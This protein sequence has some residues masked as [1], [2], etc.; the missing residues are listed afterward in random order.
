MRLLLTLCSVATAALVAGASGRGDDKS[1]GYECTVSAVTCG[2][3]VGPTWEAGLCG[4]VDLKKFGDLPDNAYT[5][6]TV[7][8]GYRVSG[9][10]IF[11]GGAGAKSG[12]AISCKLPWDDKAKQPR[13]DA[14]KKE[15]PALI[16]ADPSLKAKFP[17][18]KKAEL[19]KAFKIE[20]VKPD[21]A[22]EV[23][24]HKDYKDHPK[25]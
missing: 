6:V 19:E 22:N 15:L 24:S 21:K 14:L 18:L 5:Q 7:F 25:K 13:Y 16:L 8:V 1:S 2:E 20:P 17:G 3:M 23:L 4:V 11:L 10:V 9:E 12:M